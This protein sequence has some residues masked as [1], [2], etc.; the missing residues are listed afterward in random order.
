MR[1]RKSIVL[2][3]VLATVLLLPACVF[4]GESRPEYM[5]DPEHMDPALALALR[6]DFLKFLIDTD[7]RPGEWKLSEIWVQTYF[8]NYSGCE[9]V[10]MESQLNHTDALRPVKIG[11][12]TVVFPNGQE[13]YAYKDS[14]FY[15]LKEA[16]DAG[17]ITGSDVYDIGKQIGGVDY[18]GEVCYFEAA[19]EE[20]DTPV[21]ARTVELSEEQNRALQ[22][23]LDR[24]KDWSDDRFTDRMLFSYDGEFRLAYSGT[25]YYF[26]YESRVIYY[27]ESEEP[28]YTDFSRGYF[29]AIPAED[30]EYIKTIG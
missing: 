22:A 24:V 18:L 2:L 20:Y 29:A 13:V 10:Y 26:S 8:G 14:R 1:I 9:V 3:L 5:K 19:T 15:T 7:G 11:E 23:I 28:G 6:K 27:Y 16:F 21:V 25:E 4:P 17:W 30:M 12:Y